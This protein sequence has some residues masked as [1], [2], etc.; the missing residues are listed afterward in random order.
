MP[1]LECGPAAIQWLFPEEHDFIDFFREIDGGL[2]ATDIGQRLSIS[3]VSS[4]E[5][6][7]NFTHRQRPSAGLGEHW[8]GIKIDDKGKVRL[9]DRG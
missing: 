2:S 9:F 6:R 7:G 4:V 1:D 5:G 3:S 8:F